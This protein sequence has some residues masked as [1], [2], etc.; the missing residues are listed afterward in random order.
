MK[1]IEK[2]IQALVDEITT[3]YNTNIKYI[4]HSKLQNNLP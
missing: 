3:D 4:L 1:V 2:A